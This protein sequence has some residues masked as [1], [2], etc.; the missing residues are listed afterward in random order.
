MSAQSSEYL[1]S[2]TRSQYDSLLG[3]AL[4]N[5]GYDVTPIVDGVAEP[6]HAGRVKRYVTKG[7]RRK[8]NNF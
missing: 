8:A 6:Q 2:T 4:A 7:S 1:S 5:A 3:R